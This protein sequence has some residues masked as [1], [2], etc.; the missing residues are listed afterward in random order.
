VAGLQVHENV[1]E[2]AAVDIVVDRGIFRIQS[3]IVARGV[4]SLGRVTKV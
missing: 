2:A 4:D 3:G 1:I